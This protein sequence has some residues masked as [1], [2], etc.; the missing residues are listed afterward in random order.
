[1]RN[2]PQNGRSPL[3]A[4]LLHHPVHGQ[5]LDFLHAP[6]PGNGS[7][8]QRTRASAAHVHR[9]RDFPAVLLFKQPQYQR[10]PFP[11]REL[12][13]RAIQC[14]APFQQHH[15]LFGIG[16]A[17]QNLFGILQTGFPPA[18]ALRIAQLLSGYIPAQRS[19]PASERTAP[20]I[21]V[22][23][24]EDGLPAVLVQDIGVVVVTREGTNRRPDPGTERLY[25]LRQQDR[26]TGSKAFQVDEIR[27]RSL[28]VSRLLWWADMKSN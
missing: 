11:V 14:P 12:F 24:F 19:R 18:S 20:A 22:K 4:V 13:H 10:V 7:G 9:L 17:V 26:I 16:S 15:L 2:R 8:N 25:Q 23:L 6:Q 3:V 1:M 28:P 21:S 27:N 5:L